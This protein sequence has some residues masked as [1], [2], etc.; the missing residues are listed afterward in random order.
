MCSRPGTT[1][2]KCLVICEPDTNEF[3]LVLALPVL[4]G[5]HG[6]ELACSE[7]EL[8]PASFFRH[9]R[10]PRPSAHRDAHAAD[11]ARADA[12]VRLIWWRRR[13]FVSR[14]PAKVAATKRRS[15]SSSMDEYAVDATGCRHLTS[16]G[17]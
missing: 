11:D 10:G 15:A 1:Y 6:D 16:S 3:T 14:V 17:V 7:S 13:R 4:S 5:L 8:K 12:T 2:C 9:A